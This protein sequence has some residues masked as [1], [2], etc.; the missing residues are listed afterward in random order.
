MREPREIEKALGYI[1]VNESFL[2][3]ALAQASARNEGKAKADNRRLSFLGD[4]VL[5]MTVRHR[6]CVDASIARK[7]LTEWKKDFVNNRVI[8]K[9]LDGLDEWIVKGEGEQRNKAGQSRRTADAFEAL[10]GAIYLDGGVHAFR[11]AERLVF[12]I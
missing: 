2:D 10:L 7:Q 4:A 12:P 8:S 9:L 3:E 5:E 1:F 6:A 11:V